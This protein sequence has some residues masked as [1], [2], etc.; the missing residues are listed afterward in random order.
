MDHPESPA[1]SPSHLLSSQLEDGE[2]EGPQQNSRNQYH[3]MPACLAWV[4][5]P[6]IILSFK[7]KK[8]TCVYSWESSDNT[9]QFATRYSVSGSSF[10]IEMLRENIRGRLAS[11]KPC[12]V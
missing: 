2:H 5:F 6:T 3:Q 7:G 1:Y 11:P 8:A 10:T 9:V 4:F 12:V